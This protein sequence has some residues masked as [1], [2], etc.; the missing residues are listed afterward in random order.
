M[1]I[2][3]PVKNQEYILPKI[4]YISR[5]KSIVCIINP[6]EHFKFILIHLMTRFSKYR[7]TKNTSRKIIFRLDDNL[8]NNSLRD[9]TDSNKSSRVPNTGFNF[10]SPIF[11]KIEHNPRLIRHVL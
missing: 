2:L 3:I 1:I 6:S 11:I 8:P 5:N 7:F 4:F 10:N 9:S